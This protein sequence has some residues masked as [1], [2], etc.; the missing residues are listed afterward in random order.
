MQTSTQQQTLFST[1]EEK[2]HTFT[3]IDLFAGIGGFRIALEKAGGACLGFSEIDKEAIKTYYENF[4]PYNSNE[5]DFGDITK[6]NFLPNV[7][8]LVGGVP[9][10]SWSVAGKMK[11]FEDPRGRL[12]LDTIRMVE[13]NKPKAFIFEN[14]KGLFDPRNKK[15]LDLIISS[16]ENIGYEVQ[17]KLLN[18]F[19]F[20]LPQN[21]DRIYIV[22]LRKD[23][24]KRNSYNFPF[25]KIKNQ[26]K[27]F[28]FI[29][30]MKPSLQEKSVLTSQELFGDVVPVGRNRFQKDN[31]LNDFFVFCDTRNGHTTIHSWDII[32]TTEREKSI[33]LTLLRNRR[34]KQYGLQDGNPISLS[35]LQKLLS[36]ITREELRQLEDKK[37]IKEVQGKGFDF[38]N[39]KNSSGINDIYRVYLPESD[40]FSTLTATGTK[41]MVATES[42][43]GSSPL[44]FKKNFIE[45][46]YKQGKYRR[47]TAQEAS[48]LQGF[49][50]AF[51][52]HKKEAMAHKQFGNAVSV[53]VVYNVIISIIQTGILD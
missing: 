7:D 53:P 43:Y 17:Y 19:D 15:S 39:S 18:S 21:R 20:G 42:V 8:V 13:L 45:K 48:K 5:I 29:D 32:D 52:L 34:K 24:K 3:F 6:L 2:G 23:L 14:V 22:G 4:I 41:D 35:E 26:T 36:G 49:P 1:S 47:I 31:E 9:C 11:G 25:L 38:V 44:E 16:F 37:I 51:K 50:S 33:C 10:Q 40:I 46:I 27:L 28:S 30:G 12:W